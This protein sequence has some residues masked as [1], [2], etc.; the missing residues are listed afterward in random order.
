MK[1]AF[2]NNPFFIWTRNIERANNYL[3]KMMC[4]G[5]LNLPFYLLKKTSF[6][7]IPFNVILLLSH[8]CWWIWCLVK[9]TVSHK[10]LNRSIFIFVI[11]TLIYFEILKSLLAI[12]VIYL[13]IIVE[14][15]KEYITELKVL[16]TA[17]LH[18][19][20]SI[21]RFRVI[22]RNMFFVLYASWLY[23]ITCSHQN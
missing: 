21:T 6:F 16:W 4:H 7:K 13:Y 15:L 11:Q 5:S 19:K 22:E 12:T 20:Y 1:E 14:N 2:H 9:C 18:L 10:Y 3:E 17:W 23:C 8:Q